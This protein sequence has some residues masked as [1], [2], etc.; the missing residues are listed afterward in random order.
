MMRAQQNPSAAVLS[1]RYVA[2]RTAEA[3]G[4]TDRLLQAARDRTPGV[5][6][7]VVP[8]LYRFWLREPER[9]WGL[10]AH[11]GRDA[12]RFPG[13]PNGFATETFAELSLAIL[14]RCREDPGQLQKLAA[15]WGAWVERLFNSPL[16]KV[17]GRRLVLQLLAF[18]VA[19]VLQRQPPF[20]PLNFKELTVTFG[21][22]SELRQA[23]PAGSCAWKIPNKA[24]VPLPTSCDA[25]NWPSTST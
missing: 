20:Q 6:R 19:A 8:M 7:L 10:L 12:I 24:S 3:R 14:N 16:A 9:G 18:P 25:R 22:R 13:Y 2:I 11:I 17:L 5:R 21:H 4:F 1:A 15:I 23:W